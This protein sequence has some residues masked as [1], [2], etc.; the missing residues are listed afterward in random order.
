MKHLVLIALLA[1]FSLTVQAQAKPMLSNTTGKALDTV[2]NTGTRSQKLLVNDYQDVT[3]IVAT[4]T[5]ISGTAA[6]S[7]KC[8]GSVD[9]IDF[10]LVDANTFTP[11]D[12]AGAQ[13]Y[14]WKVN[15]SQYAWYQVTYTGVGTMAAKLSSKVLARRK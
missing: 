7:V 4:V 12:V 9:N 15:P 5:K 6:G 14:A 11:T 3:T 2:T 13:T 10:V 8:Y 1:L